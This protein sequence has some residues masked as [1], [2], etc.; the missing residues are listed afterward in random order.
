MKNQKEVYDKQYWLNKL[1]KEEL[2]RKIFRLDITAKD[3]SGG[4]GNVFEY[5]MNKI[6]EDI[7]KIIHYYKWAKSKEN[8]NIQIDEITER[9]FV[10]GWWNP[11]YE[12]QASYKRAG[13]KSDWE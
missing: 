2:D 9:D 5:D 8:V 3:Q 13:I 7:E 4:I 11:L 12:S 6:E 10:N 1:S